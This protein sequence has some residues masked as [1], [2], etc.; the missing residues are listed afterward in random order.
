MTTTHWYY[1]GLGY[2]VLFS[3]GVGTLVIWTRKKQK[4]RPPV[5]FKLLRGPG[6][7][8]R[9][10]MAKFDEDLFLRIVGAAFAPVFAIYPVLQAI[11]VLQPKTWIQL[12]LWLALAVVIFVTILHTPDRSV[13]ASLC[14]L[15]GCPWFGQGG[16]NPRA[17][18]AW[19]GCLGNGQ[20][21]GGEPSFLFLSR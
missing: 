11:V 12:N 10:R 14:G 5:D 7:T 4:V 1:I 6:E 9:R 3:V 19:G 15:A 16:P 20:P 21:P 17:L 13:T 18:F 8:L 2:F